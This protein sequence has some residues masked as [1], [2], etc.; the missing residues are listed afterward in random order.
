MDKA[1]IS[2]QKALLLL[3]RGNVERGEECL[4]DA[5]SLFQ[6]TQNRVGLL[7]AQ[8]CLG[9]LLVQLGREEEAI[10]LLKAVAEAEVDDDVV[11]YEIGRARELLVELA[12]GD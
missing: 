6:S 12:A 2:F 9:D 1:E 3:D 4:R 8:C 7:Q 5:I 11:D 10:P